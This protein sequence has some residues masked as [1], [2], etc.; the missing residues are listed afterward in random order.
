[1]LIS[2]Q[3]FAAG[4]D[5]DPGKWH[6]AGCDWRAVR[7]P[8]TCPNACCQLC[9]AWYRLLQCQPGFAP[10]PFLLSSISSLCFLHLRAFVLWTNVFPCHWEWICTLK[11]PFV[12]GVTAP[13]TSAEIW[14][15]SFC[16][17]LLP[18]NNHKHLSTGRSQDEDA[19]AL[20]L[21]L[22]FTVLFLFSNALAAI[23]LKTI[24]PE[25]LSFIAKNN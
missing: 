25:T 18:W 6:P 1:M 22:G 8:G 2:G 7:G 13:V 19:G 11:N 20:N 14:H 9:Y 23:L 10:L 17:T 4:R 12:R 15:G 16:P 24:N 5:M 3:P 21:L